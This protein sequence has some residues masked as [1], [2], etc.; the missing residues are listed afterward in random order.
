MYQDKDKN[1]LFPNKI[2]KE[3]YISD[4]KSADF[5]LRT[6]IMIFDRLPQ[7]SGQYKLSLIGPDITNVPKTRSLIVPTIYVIATRY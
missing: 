4:A 6:L 2:Q 5:R 3:M 7:V 1:M